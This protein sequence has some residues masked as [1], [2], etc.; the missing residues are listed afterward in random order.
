M[1]GVFGVVAAQGRPLSVD[2]SEARRLRDLLTHRGPD[3]AGLWEGP[4]ALLAHR[5]LA[6]LD[7]TEA[8]A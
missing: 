1:C 5:R 3:G 8:G 7:P 4:G 6:V 2:R